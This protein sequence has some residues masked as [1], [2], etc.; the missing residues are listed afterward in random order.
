MYKNGLILCK[1]KS[2]IMTS[3]YKLLLWSMIPN[4][5]PFMFLHLQRGLILQKINLRGF[6]TG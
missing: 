3:V 2:F 4:K 5:F 1:D 6:S